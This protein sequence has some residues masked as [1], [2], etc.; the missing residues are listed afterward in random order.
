MKF[1]RFFPVLMAIALLVLPSCFKDDDEDKGDYLSW[2]ELNTRAFYDSLA[3]TDDYGNKVYEE[4]TP[5]WDRSFSILLRWHNEGERNESFL[6][7]LSNSTCYV[8]Y[9]LRNIEGDTLDTSAS[10]KCVPNNL[11]TGFMAALSQMRVNDTVTAV[12]PSAAGYGGFGYGAVLPNST[13]VFGIRLDSI[14]PLF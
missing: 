4:F 13:L 5:V 10:L 14:S 2:G 11:V 12:V 1:K 3:L 6:T 9:T 7:P 8:K